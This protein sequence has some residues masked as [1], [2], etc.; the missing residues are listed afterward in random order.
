M[1]I[2][3]FKPFIPLST[4]LKGDY[5]HSC[6]SLSLLT[7]PHRQAVE[8][9]LKHGGMVS[10]LLFEIQDFYVYSRVYGAEIAD[11]LSLAAERELD[12]LIKDRLSGL[13]LVVLDRLEGDKFMLALGGY[14]TDITTLHRTGSVLRLNLRAK[15]KREAL[16]LTGQDIEI[17]MGAAQLPAGLRKKPEQAVHSALADAHRMIRGTLDPAGAILLKEFRTVL[18]SPSVRAVYQPIVDLRGGDIFAWEALARGPIESTFENPD[19]LFSFAEEHDLVFPL[20][21]ACRAAAL[22][23]FGELASG[24]TLFLNVHPRTLVDP[25]FNPGETLKLLESLGLEPHNVVLEITERH[26]TK[27]FSLFHRTLDHYRGEGY[28]VAVDDVGTGYSGL[29]SIAEIRPDFIKLDMSLIRGIDANPVKRALIETFLTFSDKV[30]CKI[31]AEGIETATE[32]SSLVS[33]GVHYGQGYFLARPASPKPALSPEATLFFQGHKRRFSSDLKCSTPIG[34]HAGEAPQVQAQSPVGDLKRYFDANSQISSV[35]VVSGRRPVGLVTRHQMDRVLSSQ[36]GLALYTNRPVTKI[37][38]TQPLIVD[39]NTPVEMAAQA[40]MTRDGYKVYDNVLVTREGL[41]AG[42]ASVQKILDALAQ[43]QM[44]MAKGANPLSGLPGNVTIE[45]EIEGRVDSNSPTSFIYADLDNFKVFNDS[46][47]FKAGDEIILLASRILSWAIR[48]HGSPADFL[49]HVGGDDFVICSTPD[50]A[51][52]ICKAVTRCF[53]RLVLSCYSET[54]R[55]AGFIVGK[56]RSG[57]EGKFGFVSVSLAI[58]DCQGHCTLEDISHRSAEMKKYAKSL[59]GN[60]WVRDRRGP[61]GLA[62]CPPRPEDI[63]C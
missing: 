14:A 45:R 7:A 28:K 49:G 32:L 52:R 1:S 38:D 58:V 2:K 60:V 29:W 39:W 35:A 30:G 62:S 10:V 34:T 17:A 26:S 54:D 50:K 3:S 16:N 59:P 25:A 19:M 22:N 6:D 33:M 21:R 24:R 56:D 41:L 57:K 36:Y 13:P 55:L 48:R 42:L 37:M 12:A 63:A 11:A 31:V 53:S 9:L 46:Y 51:E 47:G 44:E 8:T 40:A 4:P 5:P 15:L 20:E 18:N 27:D 61:L 43:V 23:G